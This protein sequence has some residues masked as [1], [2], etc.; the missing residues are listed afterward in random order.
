[1]PR[2]PTTTKTASP[3]TPHVVPEWAKKVKGYREEAGNTQAEIEKALGASVNTLSLI[4]N[5]RREFTPTQRHLFFELVGKPEDTS[6]PTTVRDLVPKV[7]EKVAKPKPVKKD[8]A[9]KSA[10][11]PKT[12]KHAK[13][14]VETPVP[15]ASRASQ[16]AATAEET[17]VPAATTVQP[18]PRPRKGQKPSTDNALEGITTY[19]KKGTK[20]EVTK[21]TR[22]T[23]TQK[24]VL[25][26]PIHPEPAQLASSK[27][28]EPAAAHAISP[29][30]EAVL[31]DIIRILNN[32]GLSDNQAKR[33]HGLFTS[34]AVNALL[35]D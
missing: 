30:K 17:A 28:A 32:P 31:R 29:V 15:N 1:M 16:G 14:P 18:D 22:K 27:P 35:G 23:R 34:L 4:E 24:L 25:A 7:S 12:A 5:G 26:A 8:K 2:K 10:K 19:V 6:I 33:L 13:A 11:A 21:P 3:K 9:T 20:D